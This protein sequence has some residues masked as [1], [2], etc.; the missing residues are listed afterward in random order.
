MKPLRVLSA[1]DQVAEHLR[2]ELMDGEFGDTMPGAPVLA[3]ELGVSQKTVKAALNLLVQQGYLE[4]QG[5]GRNR[6]IIRP[7]G[8]KGQATLRVA[9]LKY[10]TPSVKSPYTYSILQRLSHEGHQ[11][12]I[13]EK[14]LIDLDF[15]IR[16]IARL[17]KQTQADAWIVG[18]APRHVLEWFVEQDVPAIAH[19]GQRKGLPIAGVG[20]DHESAFRT[21]SRRLIELGHRRIVLLVRNSHRRGDPGPAERAVF[22]E[23]ERAGLPVGRYNLPEWEDS[24]EDFRRVLDELFRITP[25]TA[26]YIDEAFL[27]HVAKDHL[28]RKHIFAPQDV[29]LICTDPDPTFDWNEPSVA[30]NAWDPKLVINRIARWANNIAHGKDDQRQTL[31]KAEFIEGG[32]VG[33]AKH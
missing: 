24:P 1:A 33:P 27:Y 4:N 14:S 21:S 6:R 5:Q 32:T 13:A 25:P 23:M 30:H 10:D 26:M 31:T 29:S 15:D 3:A 17:V 16:R 18:A 2:V 19:F 7:K 12:F 22:D 28:A 8:E 9:F 20:P 11:P